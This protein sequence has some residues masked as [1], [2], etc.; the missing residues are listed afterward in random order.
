MDIFE[1][2]DGLVSGVWAIADWLALLSQTRMIALAGGD[3]PAE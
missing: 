1:I 2:N 3:L